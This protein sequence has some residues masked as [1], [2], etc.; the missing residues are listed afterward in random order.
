MNNQPFLTPNEYEHNR[1]N[2]AN[3]RAYLDMYERINEQGL[4]NHDEAQKLEK[5]LEEKIRQGEEA[6]RLLDMLNNSRSTLRLTDGQTSVPDPVS[7]PAAPI[8]IP[9]ISVPTGSAYIEE[10]PSQESSN[11]P[12]RTSTRYSAYAPGPLGSPHIQSGVTPY[13]QSAT[14]QSS[15]LTSAQ[16]GPHNPPQ[17]G[18]NVSAIPA[19]I[20]TGHA[21][22]RGASYAYD[23]AHNQSI[24]Y[25]PQQYPSQSVLHTSH[26]PQTHSYVPGAQGVQGNRTYPAHQTYVNQSNYYQPPPAQA[27]APRQVLPEVSSR[28]Q[29]GHFNQVPGSGYHQHAQARALPAPDSGS[30]APLRSQSVRNSMR[31]SEQLLAQWNKMT[32]EQKRA[33]LSPVSGYFVKAKASSSLDGALGPARP[34][35]AQS[36]LFAASGSSSATASSAQ[37]PAANKSTVSAPSTAGASALRDN[38]QSSAAPPHAPSPVPIVNCAVPPVTIVIPA[39][40]ATS[41]VVRP[42]DTPTPGTPVADSSKPSPSRTPG[43]ADKK[44]LA[45]DILRALKRPRP[46][47]L[48][49]STQVPDPK[50]HATELAVKPILQATSQPQPKKSSQIVVPVQIPS[51]APQPVQVQSNRSTISANRPTTGLVN[52]RDAV[53][54]VLTTS[55]TTPPL[56][57]ASTS[58]LAPLPQDQAPTTIAPI[59]PNPELVCTPVS[60]MES[61]EANVKKVYQ[62]SVATAKSLVPATSREVLPPNAVEAPPAQVVS[63]ESTMPLSQK[64]SI[65]PSPA[66]NSGSATGLSS[67]SSNTVRPAI[68]TLG[69]TA[70]TTMPVVRDIAMSGSVEGPSNLAIQKTPLFL[71]SPTPS[72]VPDALTT[73]EDLSIGGS[74]NKGKGKALGSP[75][76]MTKGNDGPSAPRLI[77]AHV[78]VPPLPEYAKKWKAQSQRSGQEDELDMIERSLLLPENHSPSPS[79]SQFRTG[80]RSQSASIAPS[81]PA[82][83]IGNNENDDR[84]EEPDATNTTFSSYDEAEREVLI[85]HRTRLRASHCRWQDCEVMLNTPEALYKHMEIEH[86]PR[87]TSIESPWTCQWTS[88]GYTVV[89]GDEY[90]QHITKH[91]I[92]PLWCP[93]KDCDESFRT[94]RQLIK[95]K[96]ND[97][98][99]SAVLRPTA[100][101]VAVSSRALGMIP[102]IPKILPSYMTEYRVVQPASITKSR[103]EVVMPMVLRRISGNVPAQLQGY[104]AARP[105]P[106]TPSKGATTPTVNSPYSFLEHRSTRYSSYLSTPAKGKNIESLNSEHV[107]DLV[108]KGLVLWPNRDS[109]EAISEDV[110]RGLDEEEEEG[111]KEPEEEGHDVFGPMVTTET[112][113]TTIVDGEMRRDPSDEEAVELMLIQMPTV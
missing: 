62:P 24:S 64:I 75:S 80:S 53:Q 49:P 30:Q 27:A 1:S 7:S 11:A 110:M 66:S 87:R 38:V 21:Q 54:P 97:H 106:E 70:S 32:E 45:R 18:R 56:N 94:P 16:S 5:A 17:S 2:I 46:A 42:P 13:F 74:V 55:N 89:S 105:M 58:T 65:V 41:T 104:N 19:S 44:H 35:I 39:T 82:D 59:R 28:G 29:Y 98:D 40:P 69:T 43:T 95:H 86:R 51:Q 3:Q 72:P 52:S 101:P 93:Y 23:P 33:A 6:K 90:R 83:M 4:K 31:H 63:L 71:A 103:H 57:A 113:G 37:Q 8:V 73:F 10:V 88:C 76:P 112:G 85:E 102:Q 50:R 9:S 67:S 92:F 96:R 78:L 84:N 109:K 79:L 22:Q 108:K 12:P 36:S 34:S 111:D 25:T 81:T 48:T 60:S 47:N 68:N 77:F 100:L 26:P 14:Q 99:S 107:T 91:T 20:S 61:R 15:Y